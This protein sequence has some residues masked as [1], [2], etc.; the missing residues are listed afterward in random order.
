M[1][2][3]VVSVDF[4]AANSGIASMTW[5]QRTI[6]KPIKEYGEHAAYFNMSWVERLP[7]GTELAAVLD[8]VRCLVVANQALRSHFRYTPDGPLQEDRKSTRLNSSHSQI[9]Y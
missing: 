6:W 8:A 9:S 3:S 4:H 1:N 5:G 2:E 7:A